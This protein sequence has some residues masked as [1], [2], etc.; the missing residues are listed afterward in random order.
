MLLLCDNAYVF[1]LNICY[2]TESFWESKC[3]IDYVNSS[4][5]LF[6]KDDRDKWGGGGGRGLEEEG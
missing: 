6:I 3:E 1:K 2:C 4:W 5:S